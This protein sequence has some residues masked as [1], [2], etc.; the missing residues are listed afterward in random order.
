[1]IDRRRFND[2]ER[3]IAQISRS[4]QYSTKKVRFADEICKRYGEYRSGK[5]LQR[6]RVRAVMEFASNV[7][8]SDLMIL[9]FLLIC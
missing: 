2:F 6:H 9:S 3:P 8:L 1:M 4:R 7:R 5:V